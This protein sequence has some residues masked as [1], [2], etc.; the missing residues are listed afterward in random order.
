MSYQF[1]N[2]IELKVIKSKTNKQNTMKNI[3]INTKISKGLTAAKMP[4][5][6]K[7]AKI[8][9]NNAALFAIIH[10]EVE[11]SPAY[12]QMRKIDAIYNR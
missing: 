8:R 2:L 11:S 10:A 4:M 6:R 12:I 5:K 1:D 3:N 9:G 7:V